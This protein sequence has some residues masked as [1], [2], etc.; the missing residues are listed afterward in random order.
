MIRSIQRDETIHDNDPVWGMLSNSVPEKEWFLLARRMK[1]SRHTWEKHLG[2]HF[3]LYLFLLPGVLYL[4]L[5]KYLPMLGVVIA[6]QD[7]NVTRKIWDLPLVGFKHFHYLFRS[8]EFARVLTNSLLL[9]LFRFAAGFPVPILLALMLNEMRSRAYK[10]TMQT[11]LYLPHFIS[12]VVVYGLMQ[13]L[14]SPTNGLI[15]HLLQSMGQAPVPFLTN[16]GYFRPVVVLSD[17]WKSMGWGTV[18]Y[19]AAIAGIDPT[20]YE[21]AIMDGASRM[22]RILHITLPMLYS[23]IVIMLVLRAGALLSNGFE[24]VYLMQN[25]LNIDVSE[26]FETYTY[27]VGIREGRFSFSTAVGLFQST[28][29]LVLILA[30]NFMSRKL[31][32]GGLW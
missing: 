18:V 22:K 29:G 5:F 17:I 4:L 16:P 32:E 7:Y 26:V 28:V 10:R 14:L 27:K 25:A 2:H 24:Q 15:N 9:S 19:M 1:W 11:I 20:Y 3:W 12:W 31:G 8:P 23:T 30:T 13:N 6:F 21:A